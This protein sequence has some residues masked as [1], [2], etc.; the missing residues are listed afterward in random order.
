MDIVSPSRMQ[1]ASSTLTVE[2]VE[3]KACLHKTGE[4]GDRVDQLFGKVAVD[5][6]GDIQGP[7]G[8]QCKE[9]VCRDG[10]RL[11]CP[12]EHKKLGQDSDRFEVDGEGPKDL[13]QRSKEAR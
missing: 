12:L 13:T 5:P 10:F 2:E 3:V 8:A 4:D 1:Q 7:V 11:A 9:V 6:V